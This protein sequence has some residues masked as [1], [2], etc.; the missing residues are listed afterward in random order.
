VRLISHRAPAGATLTLFGP[1]D[2]VRDRGKPVVVTTT[3]PGPDVLAHATLRIDNGGLEGQYTR[4]SSAV[5]TLNGVVVV[6]PSAFNPQVAVIEKSVDAHT[7]EHPE[8]RGAE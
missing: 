8:R 1:Q 4:V 7:P 6:G 3:F 2:Y 5:V